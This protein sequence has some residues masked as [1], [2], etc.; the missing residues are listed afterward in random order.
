MK[1]SV[2]GLCF[3]KTFRIEVSM[4][5]TLRSINVA[6]TSKS[7]SESD[8]PLPVSQFGATFCEGRYP[9]MPSF[10]ARHEVGVDSFWELY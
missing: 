10:V 1:S 6:S 7:L 4:Q 3:S 2:S 9:P 5:A 8:S